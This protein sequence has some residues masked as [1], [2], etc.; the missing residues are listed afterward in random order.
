MEIKVKLELSP[1]VEAA[2]GKLEKLFAKIEELQDTVSLL[3]GYTPECL[4]VEEAA[5]VMKMSI[6]SAR[7]IF[8]R[9]DFPCNNYSK[10]MTVEKSALARYLQTS[11]K[12]GD[13]W[14]R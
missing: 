7:A 3:N 12:R 5:E 1:E 11:T 6:P 10:P 9:K 8:N 14:D 2:F 13:K 4:T